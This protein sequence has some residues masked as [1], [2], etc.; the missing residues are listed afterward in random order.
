MSYQLAGAPPPRRHKPKQ[1]L[2]Y[3]SSSIRID[4][5]V[6]PRLAKHQTRDQIQRQL[7]AERPLLGDFQ[8]QRRAFNGT[9]GTQVRHVR[10]TPPRFSA[11]CTAVAPEAVFT[12]RTYDV[13]CD[14]NNVEITG[15]YNESQLDDLIASA[16]LDLLWFPAVWPETYSYT[17]SSALRTSLEIVAFDFGAVAER[18]RTH[19]RGHRLPVEAMLDAEGVLGALRDALSSPS[20]TRV[21]EPLAET[22]PKDI[23]SEYYLLPDLARNH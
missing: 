9:R 5:P 4:P 2:A 14:F 6:T 23:L 21:P 7:T 19:D 17:L 8:Q 15:R 22:L 11:I 20:S 3:T 12:F 18:L 13:L 10:C 1:S 16:D